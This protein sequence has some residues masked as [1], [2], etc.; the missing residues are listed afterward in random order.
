MGLISGIKH[1]ANGG[2]RCAGRRPLV[3]KYQIL[4][5]VETATQHV[6]PAVVRAAGELVEVGELV[7]VVPE[8]T[9]HGPQQ[10]GGEQEA[11][12]KDAHGGNPSRRDVQET[13]NSDLAGT[14]LGK[15]RPSDFNQPA[16]GSGI[17]L[18]LA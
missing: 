1:D 2:A 14:A 4:S 16:R 8:R 18:P 3:S 11:T 17:A 10:G 6:P 15:D 9:P 13:R 5:P 12:D 7:R